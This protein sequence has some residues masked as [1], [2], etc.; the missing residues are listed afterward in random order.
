MMRRPFG[1]EGGSRRQLVLFAL[2]SAASLF[3]AGCV[4]PPEPSTQERLA[5]FRVQERAFTGES[6]HAI[7]QTYLVIAAAPHAPEP[8][9]DP[10]SGSISIPP[11]PEGTYTQG[12]CVGVDRDGYLLTAAHVLREANFVVGWIDGRLQIRPARVLV[13]NGPRN[14][15]ADLAIIKIGG[16][17]D[18]CAR[19][20]SAP[21]RKERVF[22]VVCNRRPS[23]IGGALDLAGG[24]VLD[25]GTDSSGHVEPVIS[26]DVPL[27]H[28]DSGGP[29]LS[30][31][32]DL[33][34][35]NSAIEFTWFG[36]GDILGG[37]RRLSYFPDEGLVRRVI[38]A[39]RARG[40]AG[41]PGSP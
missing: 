34:G 33:I 22:A 39:D 37:F 14:G 38:A 4:S 26:T 13:K 17:L 12:L 10:R 15:G 24:T 29:L 40:P 9:L 7:L 36:N 19:F 28:G 23:G 30:G 8:T 1:S 35:I 6:I 11:S 20:G 3:L 21:A 25:G 41:S 16:H 2:S 32:G 5:S 31:A 18:Y 27:W